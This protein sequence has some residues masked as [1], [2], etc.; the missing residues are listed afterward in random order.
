[1]T[2]KR[3]HAARWRNKLAVEQASLLQVGHTFPGGKAAQ[4]L[5][6]GPSR[7]LLPISNP[8]SE[9][10]PVHWCLPGLP[11]IQTAKQK[12]SPGL[13]VDDDPRVAATVLLL[14]RPAVFPHI[15]DHPRGLPQQP[16]SILRTGRYRCPPGDPVP[17]CTSCRR[18]REACL[19][20]RRQGW[21]TD[22]CSLRRRCACGGRRRCDDSDPV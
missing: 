11:F 22:R 1:M 13:A 17:S 7:A 10:S 14:G 12:A 4:R 20:G 18:R 9:P 8:G 3:I 19:G 21:D 5:G 2:P 16:P 15:H 6:R